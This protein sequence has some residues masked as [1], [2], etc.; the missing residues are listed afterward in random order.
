VAERRFLEDIDTLE[1]KLQRI[2]G[3]RVV[4]A[5]VQPVP[6][7]DIVGG[8]SDRI[9]VRLPDCRKIRASNEYEWYF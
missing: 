5:S 1:T 4:D 3:T 7:G 2:I 8:E 6:Q 9:T